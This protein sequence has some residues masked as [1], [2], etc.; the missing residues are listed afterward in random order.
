[1]ISMTGFGRGQAAGDGL[2]VTV[3][4]TSVNRRSQELTA[5][6][7]KEYATL[8]RPL[9]DRLRCL[10]KRGKIHAAV[11][12]QTSGAGAYV[13]ASPK[14]VSVMLKRLEEIARFNAV[15]FII[16]TELLFRIASWATGSQK[17]DTVEQ[18]QSLMEAAF[19]Q[20]ATEFGQMR[21]REGAALKLD[22]ATRNALIGRLAAEIKELSA[23]NA[24]QYR[25]LLLSR[26]K[27]ANLEIS[28]EDERVLR[29][30]AI[31]AD[32]C[33]I[34]EELTRLSSH[35]DQFARTLDSTAAADAEPVGRTLEFIV[36]EM[37]RETNTI[38]SKANNYAISQKVITMKT[39]LERIREQIQNVE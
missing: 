2:T 16:D 31:F 39:E 13:L 28:L 33:D 25:E 6:L 3:E 5:S 10:G 37:G 26:L 18:V 22:L 14:E 19:N 21:Q 38:G 35:V 8:E 7:P 23:G 24:A 12:V 17:E 36:Q 34:T 32:R 1:M 9:L 15:P 29:E 4:V 11:T 20:A 27:Q 30:I